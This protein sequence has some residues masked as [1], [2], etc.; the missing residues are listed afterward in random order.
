MSNRLLQDAAGLLAVTAFVA[1]LVVWTQGL[2][3]GL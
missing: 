1:A 2:A 3:T